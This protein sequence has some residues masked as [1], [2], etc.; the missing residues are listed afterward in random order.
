ME[1]LKTK[2]V[3]W[4]H[5][6]L[7]AILTTIS[8]ALT[9]PRVTVTLPMQAI[10][11]GGVLAVHCKIWNLEDYQHVSLSREIK[12]NTQLISL[13]NIIVAQDN[14][15]AFLARRTLADG[16][17]VY[18]LTITNVQRADTGMYYCKVIHTADN[19]VA[20]SGEVSVQ[21]QYFPSEE[22][23]LCNPDASSEEPVIVTAGRSLTLNCTSERGNPPVFIQWS[24]TGTGVLPKATLVEQGNII[25]SELIVTPNRQDDNTLF[26]CEITSP[27][28][29]DLVSTCHIGPVIVIGD[30]NNEP[31]TTAQSAIHNR[32]P[33]QSS[34]DDDVLFKDEDGTT[35]M[36]SNE[37]CRRFCKNTSWEKQWMII[38]YSV[39]ALALI[40][41]IMAVVLSVIYKVAMNKERNDRRGGITTYKMSEDVYTNIG[42][43]NHHLYMS[44]DRNKA[45]MGQ[46]LTPKLE[47]GY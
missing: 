13:N 47:A 40:L 28:F 11:V 30:S 36:E 45:L 23:P 46:I 8:S 25:Y 29:P 14:D 26:L 17:M 9:E 19:N 41:L 16:A 5:I 33:N 22:Y 15:R 4:I 37:K 44:L 18:F 38:T 31:L 3:M 24:Q 6:L 1:G 20:A 7:F 35:P 42:E 34:G 21:V 2:L 39:S 12:G 32:I 27:A 43:R 10:K